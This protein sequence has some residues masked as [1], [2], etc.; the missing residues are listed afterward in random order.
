MINIHNLIALLYPASV[1]NSRPVLWFAYRSSKKKITF[2][3]SLLEYNSQGQFYG[4]CDGVLY[5]VYK[6]RLLTSKEGNSESYIR[7]ARDGISAKKWISWLKVLGF[8]QV[9]QTFCN[10]TSETWRTVSSTTTSAYFRFIRDDHPSFKKLLSNNSRVNIFIKQNSLQTKH[11]ILFLAST[12]LVLSG[13]HLLHN[14][15]CTFT[16]DLQCVMRGQ[17]F[18]TPQLQLYTLLSATYFWQFSHQIQPYVRYVTEAK[19]LRNIQSINGCFIFVFVF[20]FGT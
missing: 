3:D 7:K 5:F 20:S 19:S 4:R 16:Q 12:W 1:M 2:E 17:S 18:Y 10:R 6:S 9:L 8:S 14:L 15:F 13:M 11:Y